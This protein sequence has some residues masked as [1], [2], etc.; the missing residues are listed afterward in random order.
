M[1]MRIALAVLA[2]TITSSFTDWFFFG[3]LFHA[4]YQAYPE[5]W[6]VAFSGANEWK[7]IV[8]ATGLSAFMAGG[9]LFLFLWLQLHGLLQPI[10][11]VVTI[12]LVVAVPMILTNFIFIKLHPALLVSHALGWLIRLLLFATSFALIVDR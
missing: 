11:L 1:L 7:A 6:R 12:W 8:I 4:R 3:V 9:F 5:V 10:E 2:G